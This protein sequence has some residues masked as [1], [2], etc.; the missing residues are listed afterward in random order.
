MTRLDAE[1]LAHLTP[2]R[3]RDHERPDQE[4][5]EDDVVAEPCFAALLPVP[6]VSP[7]PRAVEAVRL[8]DRVRVGR[9]VFLQAAGGLGTVSAIAGSL[10]RFGTFCLHRRVS[11]GMI[12]LERPDGRVLRIGHRGAPVACAGEH[13][14]LVRRGARPR[15]GHGRAG[16]ARASGR[17]A[18]RRARPAGCRASSLCSSTR[19]SSS[20]PRGAPAVQVDLKL[21]DP[22]GVVEA[23]APARAR[24][25]RSRERR[26]C[27]GPPAGGRARAGAPH[28]VHLPGGP[29]RD[30]E[31]GRAQRSHHSRAGADAARAAVRASAACSPGPARRR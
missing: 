21:R 20:S 18:R 24:R 11:R 17:K 7:A 6:D 10:G 27:R 28:L 14:A 30:D 22:S 9:R 16:R 2:D 4:Q 8:A 15:H 5:E 12:S 19:R 1:R 31:A 3:H 25:A 13:A 26:R 29:A 23:R